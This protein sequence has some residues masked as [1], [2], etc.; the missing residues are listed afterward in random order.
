[1]LIMNGFLLQAK[2]VDDLPMPPL[3]HF[4]TLLAFKIF[5]SEKVN[6]AEICLGVERNMHDELHLQNLSEIFKCKY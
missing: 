6:C 5:L 2:V 3:F 1:M 4:L